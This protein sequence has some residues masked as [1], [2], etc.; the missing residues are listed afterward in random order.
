MAVYT[1]VSDEELDAFI[2]TYDIGKVTAFKGIAEGVENSNY[3]MKT[4]QGEFILTLYEKRVAREDLPFF[5]GLMEHLAD[6]GIACPTPIKDRQGNTLRELAGRPCAVIS[7][8]DGISVRRPRLHHCAELG[9]ALA[10]L[11]LAT[12]SYAGGRTNTLAVKD[13]RGLFEQSRSHANDI[14]RGLEDE[15]LIELDAL[16]K[17]W[18]SD[19][20]QGVIHADM[21]PNNVFFIGDRLSG[22]IDYYFACTDALVYDIGICLNAWCFEHDGAF[23]TTK[24][25]A[26]IAAYQSVR[27]LSAEEFDALPIMARGASLRFL[28][29]RLYDW[30]NT[31]EGAL[32]KPLDPLEYLHKL[33]FHRHIT[34]SKEYGLDK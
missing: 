1:E 33:R 15:L 16:E 12:S 11:H 18:P 21:F 6:Q 19:L 8:L 10:G 5:I 29:T 25:R 26:L 23:N 13:W 17:G 14:S 22:I 9:Q 32:V 4:D 24:A 34:S 28:L 7:F 20:P 30:I 2:A 3:L 31:P 27:P